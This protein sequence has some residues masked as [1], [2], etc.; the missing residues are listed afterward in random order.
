MSVDHAWDACAS[1]SVGG[2]QHRCLDG[3]YLGLQLLHRRRCDAIIFWGVWWRRALP[4]VG[5]WPSGSALRA[6]FKEMLYLANQKRYGHSEPGFGVS[7][8]AHAAASTRPRPARG[9]ERVDT[10]HRRR[11]SDASNS[12]LEARGGRTARWPPPPVSAPVPPPCPSPHAPAP[13]LPHT[14]AQADAPESRR[15]VPRGI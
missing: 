10:R 13:L 11:G 1:R 9:V 6:V 15:S 7:W 8:S 2:G 4:P 3:T 12:C 14:L 5:V